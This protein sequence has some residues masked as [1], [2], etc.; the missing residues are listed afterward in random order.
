LGAAGEEI[1]SPNFEVKSDWPFFSFSGLELHRVTLIEVFYLVA[2]RHAAAVEEN[3][4]A[5]IIGSN[6]PKTLWADYFL[7]SAG[8]NNFSS[9]MRP[10]PSPYGCKSLTIR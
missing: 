8:H 9:S 2:R 1:I 7:D 10:K 5:A 4:F 6:E 3:L